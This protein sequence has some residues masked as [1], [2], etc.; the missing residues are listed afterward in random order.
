MNEIKNYIDSLISNPPLVFRLAHTF[1]KWPSLSQSSI[2]S[3]IIYPQLFSPVFRIQS[4][5]PISNRY[6]RSSVI[7][8]FFVSSPTAI[9]FRIIATIID[10]F[11][12]SVSYSKFFYM[13]LVRRIHITLKII[14]RFP[15]YFYASFPVVLVFL[16]SWIFTT[17]QHS[18]PSMIKRSTRHSMFIA[19]CLLTS[20][21]FVVLVKTIT[22]AKFSFVL[23]MKSLLTMFA[24]N[25][26]KLTISNE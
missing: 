1:F 4:S 14:K 22:R 5:F 3:I 6:I 17:L 23:E 18:S 25:N 7:R 20:S 15:K 13:G 19:I 2:K 24:L 16:T 8:L 21:I 11:N 12:R 10:T 26:H 9:S